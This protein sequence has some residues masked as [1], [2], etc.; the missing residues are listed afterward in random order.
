[1]S[2][3]PSST[4]QD[5]K[6]RVTPARGAL[7]LF[8]FPLAVIVTIA[9]L[10]WTIENWRGARAWSALKRELI[11]R[12]EPLSFDQ[13]IPPMPP[14]QQNFAS[15]P[16]LSGL[17]NYGGM[18]PG[19]GQNVWRSPQG[20]ARLRA[21]ALPPT[22][23][24]RS[25]HS[26]ARRHTGVQPLFPGRIDFMSYALGIRMRPQNCPSDLDA[27]LAE[28]YGFLP[29]GVKWR[30]PT[31]E[32]EIAASIKDPTREVL[33]YLQRFAPELEEIQEA[34]RR[35]YSQ[36]AVHWS[37]GF[38]ALL[39]HL[40]ALKQF[41]TIFSLRSAARLR[42]GD[43]AG[44]FDD[45]M[46]CLRLAKTLRTEPLL[47]SQLVAFAQS[48][49]A[50]RAV[51]QGQTTHQ[52]SADQLAAFQAELAGFDFQTQAI[53]AVR[54]ERAAHNEFL[55][56]FSRRGR[57][58]LEEAAPEEPREGVM[59]LAVPW[60]PGWVRQNQVRLNRY[61]DLEL[62]QISDPRWPASLASGPEV[63][64]ARQAAGL[65]RKDP[66]TV[67]AR[68]LAADLGKFQIKAA[69]AQTLN[70]LA[71]TACALE[72]FRIAHGAYPK[73]LSELK[74]LEEPRLLQDP[75]GGGPLS[76]ERDE[77]N[78]FRL[79]S[80]GLNGAANGGSRNGDVESGGDWDWPQA[81]TPSDDA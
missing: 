45:A 17:F 21:I 32:V 58:A 63:P 76:Y 27:A 78:G 43:M 22:R 4:E 72:R 65:A 66:Y 69:R 19:G 7:Y 48:S 35:P 47:I 50:V 71:I 16:L 81:D 44:A 70:H 61:D 24:L 31:N 51:W 25:A 80:V 2:T 18:G 23:E 41:E 79:W 15:T 53:L 14:A 56:N 40:A 39:P 10:A 46:T 62:R 11:A 33:E 5:G 59:L 6:A 64:P 20:L 73:D 1:M 34:V 3:Y 54:G 67:V 38:N 60:V 30:K 28:R 52:W 57:T 74:T 68:L 42:T 37:E 55:N 26:G 29:P 36:F 77:T 49:L 8:V 13:L 12:G 9:A 75:M